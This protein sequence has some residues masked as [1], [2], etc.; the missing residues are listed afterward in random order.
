MSNPIPSGIKTQT[1]MHYVTP[2]DPLP[3]T[4]TLINI[5]DV[6]DVV[7]PGYWNLDWSHPDRD[8]TASRRKIEAWCAAHGAHYYARGRTDFSQSEAIE[9]AKARG[10]DRV[11]YEDLS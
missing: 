5:C 8:Y 1:V 11:V 7:I 2:T 9:E 10:L 6:I 4:F 3:G